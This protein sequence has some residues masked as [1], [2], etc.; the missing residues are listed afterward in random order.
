MNCLPYR[1]ML[2]EPCPHDV[3]GDFREYSTFF[4]PFGATVVV[5]VG[6]ALPRTYTV[7]QPVTC[8]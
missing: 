2:E 5:F 7:V 6:S 4:V 8:N 3:G 1:E